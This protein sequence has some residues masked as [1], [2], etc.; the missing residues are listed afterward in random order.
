MLLTS[1]FATGKAASSAAKTARANA[2][3]VSRLKP[4]PTKIL[5][6]VRGFFC[7]DIEQ[8]SR[9]AGGRYEAHAAGIFCRAISMAL[10]LSPSGDLAAAR[11]RADA[12]RRRGLSSARDAF[13]AVLT[14]DVPDLAFEMDGDV[15]V[16]HLVAEPVRREIFPGKFWGFI[17][18]RFAPSHDSSAAGRAR[19]GSLW[20]IICRNQFFD[21]LAW[22]RHSV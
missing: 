18:S 14:P 7:R 15:E 9:I 13:R 3:A 22:V 19:C 2:T 5:V 6:T 1:T 20:T 10:R 12:D 17:N 21:A 16:F 8:I 4:L 11:A